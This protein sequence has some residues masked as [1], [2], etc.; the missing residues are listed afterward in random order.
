MSRTYRRP[1]TTG[2]AKILVK[3]AKKDESALP[4]D[5]RE[6]GCLVTV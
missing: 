2:L 5:I 1:T 3:L 6:G 4:L